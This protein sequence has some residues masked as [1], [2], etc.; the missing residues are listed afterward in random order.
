ML[1]HHHPLADSTSSQSRRV[2]H[3]LQ[4][5]LLLFIIN[6]CPYLYSIYIQVYILLM[7]YRPIV[8]VVCRA[9]I[10]DRPTD[11]LL[12]RRYGFFLS[13]FVVVVARLIEK[14]EKTKKTSDRVGIGRPK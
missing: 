9:D 2:L 5:L 14:E 3:H 12:R 10:L 1:L 7:L 4:H 13:F 11:Y 8:I 6:K